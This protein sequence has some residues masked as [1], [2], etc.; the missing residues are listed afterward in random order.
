MEKK[1]AFQVKITHDAK[2]ALKS[3]PARERQDIWKH[4]AS[5]QH[6]PPPSSVE[7]LDA[8]GLY[9]RWQFKNFLV[10]YSKNLESLKITILAVGYARGRI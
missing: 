1:P 10:L 8:L 4:I 3:F 7:Q 9:Y 5:L 2:S 6:L